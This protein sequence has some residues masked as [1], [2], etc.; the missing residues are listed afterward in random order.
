MVE[1]TPKKVKFLIWLVGGFFFIS[2]SL[3]ATSWYISLKLKPLIRKEI[4]ELVKKSTNGLYQIEFSTIHTNFITGSASI[5]DVKITPDTTVFKELITQQKAPNNLYYIELK[6]LL[7][8][9]FH[10]FAMYFNRDAKIGLLLFDK[11]KVTMVNKHF[12]FNENRPPRPR[13]S[14]YHYIAKLF[15]S[16]RIETI[17]FKDANFKYVNNNGLLPD[18]DSV[19]NLNVT[20][21]DWLIDEYS[22][23]DTSRLYLLKD[24]DIHVTN[25]SYATPDSMYYIKI[26]QLDFTASSGKLNM[27]Q[28]GLLPR[29][30]EAN[31]AKVNGYARDRFSIKLNN[32]AMEGLNLPAYIQKQELIA[33]QLHITDGSIAVYNDAN[34]PKREVNRSGRFPHQLLQLLKAKLTIKTI[35][36]SDINISY[37]ES[38]HDSKQTGKITFEKTSGVISNIT[39]MEKEKIINP[40]LTAN[41][42]TYMMGQGKLVIDFAFD[43]NSHI[44]AF[45]Y[46]GALTNLDGRTL[47][48]ITKPLGM[49]QV[50]KGEIKKLSFEIKADENFANGKLDFVYNDLSV[51]LLKKEE[52]KERLVRKGLISFL[53]NNLVIYAD[54]PSKEGN[55]TSAVIH[56]K[57]KTTASFFNYIW[58]T[59]YQ[60]VKYSVGV[61]P[62]KE[63]EIKAQIAKFEKMKAD[64][65][66]RRWRR[67]LRKAGKTKNA[68]RN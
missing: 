33:K 13:K 64:R 14:P 39:N 1:K 36:L 61:T 41:L 55:F 60:G 58:K 46:S 21:K 51:A 5:A 11:P 29:Y 48:K 18:I 37:A 47:N 35:N 54:N 65:E 59:L 9:H 2:L 32:L 20:L 22:A 24:I 38:D 44:G 27:K 53:A 43:L 67:Q 17:D 68:L 7:I 45:D 31:F 16:L 6:K 62:K 63:A 3:V 56:Y 57:R 42:Q 28:L 34:F 8:Q 25:Y 30:N 19:A 49:V 15:K 52:G 50:N 40:Q 12:E 10:P 26:N 66:E 23:T 4:T